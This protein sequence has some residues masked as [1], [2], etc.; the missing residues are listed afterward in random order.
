MNESKQLPKVG[1]GVWIIRNNKVL[2]GKRIGKHGYG[3]WAP[4]GGHLEWNEEIERCVERETEE[5]TGMK[6]KCGKLFTVTNNIFPEE[7]K[8]TITLFYF[9]E[10]TGEPKVMELDNFEKWEWFSWNEL[11]EPLFR[12]VQVLKEKGL[13]PT[14]QR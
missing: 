6:A 7:G 9:C 12:S 1:V 13:D 2:M 14:K 10:A 4:P 11:P 3:T 5:E 8:H